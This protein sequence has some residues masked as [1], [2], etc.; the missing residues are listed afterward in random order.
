MVIEFTPE[1]ASWTANASGSF[2]CLPHPSPGKALGELEG[3][4]T[5]TAEIRV[6]RKKRSLDANGYYWALCG[7]IARK[8]NLD[9]EEVYRRHIAG[10][11][12]YAVFGMRE[13]A[14]A[15]FERMW[16][17][18]H[19]GRFIE[20]KAAKTPGV[21]NVLAYYGSSDFDT[22]QMSRLIDNCIQD[23]KALDIETRSPEDIKSLLEQWGEND[24][25]ADESP[26]NL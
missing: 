14:V 22:V 3:G 13:E 11:G 4:K 9:K 16:G 7:E 25:P 2:L 26:A 10:L 19:I 8:L 6:K 21:V 20:T 5:Y 15:L 12:N 1:A 17:S 24:A 23:C 18:G